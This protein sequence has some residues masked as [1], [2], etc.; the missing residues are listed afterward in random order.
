MLTIYKNNSFTEKAEKPPLPE[1][2]PMIGTENNYF[3]IADYFIC[4]CLFGAKIEMLIPKGFIFD[5]ASIPR[6]FWRVVGHPFHPKRV[7]AALVHDALFGKINGRVKIWIGGYLIDN[8]RAMKF[9][10][11]KKTDQVFEGLLKACKNSNFIVYTMYKAVRYGGFT[12][13]RKSENKF[14]NRE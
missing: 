8:E 4:F 14:I 2:S 5:G 10:D 7:I 9:F 11:R 1:L 13:F 3:L 12:R 6:F